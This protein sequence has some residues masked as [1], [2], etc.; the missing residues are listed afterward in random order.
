VRSIWNGQLVLDLPG[1]GGLPI[2]LASANEDTTVHLTTLHEKC[3]TP[4]NLLKWCP[5]CEVVV[6]KPVKGKVVAKETVK[7]YEHEKGQF[8]VLTD[9]ELEAL[10][11]I[12]DKTITVREFVPSVN[13]LHHDR[14]YYL[15]PP[16]HAAHAM[17]YGVLRDTMWETETV[18]IGQFTFRERE[19]LCTIWPT[20]TAL[21]LTTLRYQDEVRQPDFDTPGATEVEAREIMRTAIGMLSNPVLDWSRYQNGRLAAMQGIIEAKLNGGA[22]ALV[23]P[24]PQPQVEP[25]EWLENLKQS[26]AKKRRRKEKV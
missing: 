1:M 9:Y 8:V 20:P 3:K 11:I 21:V 23:K 17:F 24:E 22:F 26:V 7:G 5:A 6:E 4:I 18:A 12:S 10:D 13:P 14:N 15:I 19:H 16:K 25:E 2:Q